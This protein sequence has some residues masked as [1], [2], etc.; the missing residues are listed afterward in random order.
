[1][2]VKRGGEDG[3]LLRQ[4][5]LRERFLDSSQVSSHRKA[6]VTGTVKQLLMHHDSV[7]LQVSCAS[8]SSG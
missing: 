3:G 6:P 5:L 7:I 2:I 8:G 4:A 1:M